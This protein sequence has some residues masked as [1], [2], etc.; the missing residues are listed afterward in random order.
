MLELVRPRTD[1]REQW[2]AAHREWGPGLHEDGFGIAAEDDV[3]S[4]QGFR[5]W[6]DLLRRDPTATWWIV[7]GDTVVGGIAL[8]AAHDPR[9][10]RDGHLG[11]GIRPSARGRGVASWAVRQVLVRA[12]SLGID[13]VVAVCLADN[14]GS[15]AVLERFASAW[16]ASDRH[17]GVAVRRFGLIATGAGPLQPVNPAD[18]DELRAFLQLADLTIAGLDDPG[19]RVWVEH[20]TD[21]AITG[22]TG[23]ERSADGQHVLVRS[24]AVAED[25]RAA[26]AGTRLA[27]FAL[28]EAAR[29]GAERAWLFSR[30]SGPFWKS[31]GFVPADRDELASRLADTQQVRLFAETG[32]LDREIAWTMP[33]TETPC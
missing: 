18:V 14:A 16:T 5:R 7:D 23:F 29:S 27:R 17:D 21:G 32:Q 24:V 10:Q 3:D 25:A 11:Y 6:V 30:R 26:G 22:S 4:E 28:A 13:P 31:L 20:G 8:R 1:L 9:V 2:L 12:A 15:V 33:L 19:L